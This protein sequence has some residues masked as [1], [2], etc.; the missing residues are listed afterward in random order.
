M[1]Q[2]RPAPR[3][4]PTT[5]TETG[6]FSVESTFRYT[7]DIIALHLNVRFRGADIPIL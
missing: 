5:P 4:E 3:V 1:I 2:D 7:Q 6:P